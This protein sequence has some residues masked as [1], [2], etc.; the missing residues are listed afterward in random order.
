MW[1]QPLVTLRGVSS[2]CQKSG[3]GKAEVTDS[4]GCPRKLKTAFIDIVTAK[5]RCAGKIKTAI[6]MYA[7]QMMAKSD[8]DPG[9]EPGYSEC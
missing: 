7:I 2:L 3:D 5:G 6:A 4:S 8:A 9:F 1:F